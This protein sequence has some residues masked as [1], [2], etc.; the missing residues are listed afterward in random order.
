MG[1]KRYKARGSTGPDPALRPLTTQEV[2]D[3]LR[4]HSAVVYKLI[5]SGAIGAVKVGRAWRITKK[6]FDDYL[7]PRRKKRG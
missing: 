3:L 4:V 5:R 6:S 2:A 7:T 1:T